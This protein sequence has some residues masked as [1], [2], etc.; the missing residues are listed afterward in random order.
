VDDTV[1]SEVP[2]ESTP[3]SGPAIDMSVLVVDD[4]P[5]NVTSLEK[6]FKKE[7]M[8]VVGAHNAR[9][10]LDQLRKRRMDVV[11]TDLMMPGITGIELLR[12]V[13]EISPDT[14]VVVMTALVRSKL[15]CR[16]CAK[17]P[18]ILSRNR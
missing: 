9:E 7:G 8:R 18:T 3:T 10:A 17:V 11:L 15:Q 2:D 6:I 12:A 5:N 14:E 16:R 1:E 13:K 4:E